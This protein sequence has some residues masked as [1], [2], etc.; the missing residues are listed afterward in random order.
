VKTNAAPWIWHHT[1]NTGH[2]TELSITDENFDPKVLE[3]MHGMTRKPLHGFRLFLYS[4]TPASVAFYVLWN[5]APVSY[6]QARKTPEGN[7]DL[8]TSLTPEGCGMDPPLMGMMA[9]LEQC[10]AIALLHPPK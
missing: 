9:D 5:N 1:T 10:A 8:E 2:T 7:I 3:Q 4:R 6:N